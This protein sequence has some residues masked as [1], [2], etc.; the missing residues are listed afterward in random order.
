VFGRN[1]SGV[2]ST[3]RM[4][5]EEAYKSVQSGGIISVVVS[6]QASHERPFHRIGFLLL[7]SLTVPS[8]TPSG[9]GN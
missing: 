5:H 8:F 2:F 1:T 9:A 4:A 3:E 7:W 6:P